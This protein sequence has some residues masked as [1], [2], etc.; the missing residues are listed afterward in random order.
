MKTSLRSWWGRTKRS[1]WWSSEGEVGVQEEV[2]KKEGASY[3]GGGFIRSSPGVR[4]K[5]HGGQTCELTVT[6]AN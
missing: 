1:D 5:R 2:L 6:F 4:K 3:L